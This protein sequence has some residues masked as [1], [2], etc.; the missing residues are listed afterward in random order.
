MG[1]E[2]FL[3]TSA[4]DCVLAQR[5]ARRLC[6]RCKIPF[7]PTEFEL[8]AAKWDFSRASIEDLVFYRGVGC[9]QCG[10]TGYRGRLAIHEVMLMSEELDK[11][12]VSRA[13]SEDVRRCAAEQGM[14][15]LRSDGLAKVALGLT[16]LSE[17]SRVVA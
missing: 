11:L 4:V 9:P 17:V 1:I 6:D 2:P 16:T 12:V 15:D 5:L 14:M 13:S 7:V 10:G 8:S 3:V